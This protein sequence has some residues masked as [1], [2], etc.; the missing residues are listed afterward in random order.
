LLVIVQGVCWW[1]FV[2]F[3]FSTYTKQELG[4][5]ICNVTTNKNNRNMWWWKIV[6]H[7]GKKH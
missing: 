3:D 5:G 1:I 7:N 6:T 4:G 2:H